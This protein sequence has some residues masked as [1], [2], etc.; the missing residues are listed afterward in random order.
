MESFLSE[1]DKI[2]SGSL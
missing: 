1:N 2:L